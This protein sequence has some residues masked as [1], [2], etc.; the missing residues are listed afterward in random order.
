[1][2]FNC[3]ERIQVQMYLVEWHIQAHICFTGNN[4]SVFG[5]KY[6]LTLKKIQKSLAL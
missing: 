5:V 1:M 4:S 2:L 3:G 6:F